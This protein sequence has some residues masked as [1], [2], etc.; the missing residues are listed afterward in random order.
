MATS[1][2]RSVLE[3]DD[4]RV[5]GRL[6][7]K[8]AV[9]GSREE[10]IGAGASKRRTAKSRLALGNHDFRDTNAAGRLPLAAC[11]RKRQDPANAKK[12]E[13]PIHATRSQICF[14]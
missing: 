13:C 14:Q 12:Q 9:G 11:A 7:I 8:L 2:H 5:H 3:I 1:I 6:R 10:L 4:S